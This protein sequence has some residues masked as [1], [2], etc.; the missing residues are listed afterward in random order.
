LSP[1]Q[2]QINF[3]SYLILSQSSFH[4]NIISNSF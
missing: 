1:Y 3:H 2:L 4:S